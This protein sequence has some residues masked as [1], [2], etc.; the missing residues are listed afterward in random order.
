MSLSLTDVFSDMLVIKKESNVKKNEIFEENR[1]KYIDK[2]DSYLIK[3]VKLFQRILR[4]R[5][6]QIMV[7]TNFISHNL[8]KNYLLITLI[9][10]YSS[11]DDY[12]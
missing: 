3:H 4:G 11:A 7:E 9:I 6:Y 8:D 2:E 1:M 5:A 12:C 10:K